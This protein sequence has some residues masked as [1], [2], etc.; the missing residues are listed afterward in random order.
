M[1]RK[2]VRKLGSPT[3]YMADTWARERPDLRPTD[4]L[5]LMYAVRLGRIIDRLDD[6]FMRKNFGISSADMRVLFI[7]RRTHTDDPPR[8]AD[9]AHAQ[10]VTTGA[11]T[12]QLDRLEASDLV[13]RHRNADAYVSVTITPKGLVLADQAI[14]AMIES[15]P[16]SAR[17]LAFSEHD[18]N[19]LTRLCEKLLIELEDK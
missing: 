7:L 1:P 9:L 15:S 18:R 5:F 12:K 2:R 6:R 10:I 14:T 19:K 4:Y 16:L 8:P 13:E 17:K 11:M 3:Q